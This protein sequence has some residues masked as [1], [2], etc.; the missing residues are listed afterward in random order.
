MPKPWL[1]EQRSSPVD[2]P[3]SQSGHRPHFPVFAWREPSARIA[4]GSR[5]N[6]KSESLQFPL[7]IA[8]DISGARFATRFLAP[9]GSF[10]A[11]QLLSLPIPAALIYPR[12]ADIYCGKTHRAVRADPDS[13]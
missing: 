6:R 7:A 2:T 3:L 4:V 12:G 1:C 10:G 9:T 11:L 8:V 5:T 13:G